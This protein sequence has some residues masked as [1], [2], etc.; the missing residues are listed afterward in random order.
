VIGVVAA[1]VLALAAQDSDAAGDALVACAPATLEA[2]FEC[3]DRHWPVRAEFMAQPYEALADAH[4]GMGMWMRNHWQMWGGGPL[5][6]HFNSLGIHHPDDMSSIV[7]E[8]YW[9]RMHDC[10]IRLD[11]QVAYY[12]AWWDRPEDSDMN[13]YLDSQPSLDCTAQPGADAQ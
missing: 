9:L 6:K 5:A 12:Q 7:L 1:S 10:P 4:F 2:A 11:E 8:S 3:L 13:D